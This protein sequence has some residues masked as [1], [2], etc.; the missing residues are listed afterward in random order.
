[1]NGTGIAIQFFPDETA[2]WREE[3][4]NGSHYFHQSKKMKKRNKTRFLVL[5]F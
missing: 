4:T 2:T 1:M 3:F 5:S